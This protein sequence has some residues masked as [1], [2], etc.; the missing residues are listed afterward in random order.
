[1]QKSIGIFDYF[2]VLRPTLFFPVWTF[3]LAGVWAQDRFNESIVPILYSVVHSD[4]TYVLYL[5]S[6]TLVMGG[7][8]LLNQLED[9]E[10]DRLN[11]KL[12]L[13]ADGEISERNAIFETILIVVLP[14]ILFIFV[15]IDLAVMLIISFIVMGWFY[16]SKPFVLKDKPI[17]GIVANVLGGYIVF[18][19][20]WMIYG[21][22]SW[23]MILH[24]TP[25]TLG[26]QAV[27]FFTTIPD[28]V[29]DE[30]VNKITIAVKFS[31][32][33]V[34]WGG[35]V[36][37][38]AA[39]IFAILVGDW[40]VLI[41]TVL[42]LPFFVYAA[43]KKSDA[44]VLR[45]NKFAALFLSLMICVRFPLYLVLITFLFYFSRWYYKARFNMDYPSFKN[46]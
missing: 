36:L 30:K 40:I 19:F 11:H 26:M 6:L 22:P 25:Y 23:S 29:G 8:F 38:A 41:P 20:G 31:R 3:A 18:S 43:I 17:G 7:T 15:R 28:R 34:L 14:I 44:E 5:V 46:E 24:A 45:T 13:I 2:F 12:F 35:V 9:I 42:V 33:F 37:D 27:Y 32:N 4:F 10:T 1:M 16:S 21:Q 39:I